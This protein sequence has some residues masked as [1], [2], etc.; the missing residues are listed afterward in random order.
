MTTLALLSAP[1]LFIAIGGFIFAAGALLLL[2][3]LE[4]HGPE[5]ERPEPADPV[6]FHSELHCI[7]SSPPPL[8]KERLGVGRR[9]A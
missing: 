8:G 4:S 7:G 5:R 1:D 2:A 3:R 6:N 9:A